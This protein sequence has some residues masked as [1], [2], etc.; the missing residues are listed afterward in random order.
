MHYVC[1]INKLEWQFGVHKSPDV[2]FMRAHSIIS[3]AGR[4]TVVNR[5]IVTE[6]F[7]SACAQSSTSPANT[8]GPVTLLS[9]AEARPGFLLGHLG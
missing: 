7:W 1:R 9:V 5:S 3:I 2:R 8:Y 6:I 4:L